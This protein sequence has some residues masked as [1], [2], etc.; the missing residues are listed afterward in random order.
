MSRENT[1][2]Y[3]EEGSKCVSRIWKLFPHVFLIVSLIGYA[4]FGALIFQYIEGKSQPTAKKDYH[5][6]LGNVV[7]LIQNYS[8]KLYHINIL[9]I[10][11]ISMSLTHGSPIH[12]IE[13][14]TIRV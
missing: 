6:F 5:N 11:T 12:Y 14:Y 10:S 13:Y 4:T 2:R 1:K 3:S 7:K 8:G 9:Q